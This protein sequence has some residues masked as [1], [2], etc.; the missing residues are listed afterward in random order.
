MRNDLERSFVVRDARKKAGGGGGGGGLGS[1]C[2][3]P[4]WLRNPWWLWCWSRQIVTQRDHWEVTGDAK[5]QYRPLWAGYCT[6][7]VKSWEL[8]RSFSSDRTAQSSPLESSGLR[9][10]VPWTQD[11]WLGWDFILVWSFRSTLYN[12]HLETIGHCKTDSCNWSNQK[13]SGLRIGKGIRHI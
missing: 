10:C 3:V 11:S 13:I 12:I 6:H 8:R 7:Q 5:S 2:S 4:K 1:C 9:K